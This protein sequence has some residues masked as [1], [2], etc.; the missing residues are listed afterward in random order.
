MLDRT[1]SSRYH[2]VAL[3][4][5]GCSSS[6]LLGLGDLLVVVEGRHVGFY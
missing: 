4:I 2:A 6:D 3:P 1:R 5:R